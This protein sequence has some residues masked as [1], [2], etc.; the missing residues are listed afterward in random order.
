MPDGRWFRARIRQ[1]ISV[2]GNHGWAGGNPA[3]SNGLA[4]APDRGRVGRRSIIS[5]AGYSGSL[6]AWHAGQMPTNSN[7]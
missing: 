7:W 2:K 6:A 5:I 3:G 4:A 1:R